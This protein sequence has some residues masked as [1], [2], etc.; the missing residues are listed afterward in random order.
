[1]YTDMQVTNAAKLEMKHLHSGGNARALFMDAFASIQAKTLLISNVFY[2]RITEKERVEKW[3]FVY[4]MGILPFPV[5]AMC[6]NHFVPQPNSAIVR[7]AEMLIEPEPELK[8]G[9]Y[10]AV[11]M[12]RGDFVA[13]YKSLHPIART[14]EYVKRVSLEG[15]FSTMVLLTDGTPARVCVPILSHPHSHFLDYFHRI[16]HSTFSVREDGSME[17]RMQQ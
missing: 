2:A 17:G 9:H 16:L 10:L 6:R 7:S 8:S 3:D 14:T 12:R 15:G 5:L 4:E 11:H 1:M 13:K